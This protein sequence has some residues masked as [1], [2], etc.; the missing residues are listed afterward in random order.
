MYVRSCIQSEADHIVVLVVR[1]IPVHHI[2]FE[3][4][5]EPRYKLSD[6][7]LLGRQRFLFLSPLSRKVNDLKT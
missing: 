7:M 4:S 6:T 5:Q 3:G 2:T 1:C